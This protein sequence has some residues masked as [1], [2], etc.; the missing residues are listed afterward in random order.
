MPTISS[1]LLDPEYPIKDRNTGSSNNENKQQS[2]AT[3]SVV[4]P[5]PRELH[6]KDGLVVVQVQSSKI[7]EVRVPEGVTLDLSIKRPREG[8]SYSDPLPIKHAQPPPPPGAMYRTPPT[9]I[10]ETNTFYSPQVTFIFMIYKNFVI[11]LMDFS[12]LNWGE[13]VSKVKY[14]GQKYHQQQVI[15]LW[16]T[17]HSLF[18]M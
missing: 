6:N 5:P 11:L 15:M 18:L 8:D 7:S 17:H 13:V 14:I 9:Q 16:F 10:H 4:P 3:I 12:M 2:M 1:I